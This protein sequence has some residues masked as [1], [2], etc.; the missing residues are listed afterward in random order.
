[1]HEKKF[2]KKIFDYKN[3]EK[4]DFWAKNREK[5]AKSKNLVEIF[6]G[7]ESIQNGL[8]RILKRKS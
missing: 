8:N 7:S 5:M 3:L 4:R 6:F 2:S 1:M